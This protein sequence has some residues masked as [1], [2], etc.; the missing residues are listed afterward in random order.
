[1]IRRP[2]RS[3]LFPYTTLF[4]SG[5]RA[6]QSVCIM[7]P[8][9]RSRISCWFMDP[10]ALRP[11]VP[12]DTPVI[13]NGS[14]RA[15]RLGDALRFPL[16]AHGFYPGSPATLEVEINEHA[17]EEHRAARRHREF[18]P[19]SQEQPEKTLPVE[20]D[21]ALLATGHAHVG[22][23]GRPTEIGRAHV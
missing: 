8:T 15:H 11:T 1:M 14:L 22:C 23:V 7:S 12:F 4:R 5:L 6:G 2:P 9:L 19:L 3:T 21:D 18:S 16:P 17:A 13:V 20:A 10:L